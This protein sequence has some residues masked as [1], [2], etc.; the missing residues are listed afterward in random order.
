MAL[1]TLNIDDRTYE[2]LLT[3]LK[4]H[5]PVAE[6][7]D[8][9]PSDPGIMLLELLAW[10]GEMTLYR[11]NRVPEPHKRKFLKLLIDPPEPVMVEVK[12]QLKLA[13]D[14]TDED[15]PIPPGLRFATGFK[16]GKRYT[17]ETFQ[18]T[19]LHSPKAGTHPITVTARTWRAIENE[20]LGVSDG[21]PNQIF[22][23]KHGPVLLDF[24]NKR[25]EYEIVPGSKWEYNPNPEIH[26]NGQPWEL[27]QSLRT[28][29]SKG[30]NKKHVMV[31]DFENVVRFGD[32]EFGAIPTAGTKL[33]CTR[34]QILEGPEALIKA[35]TIQYV[36]NEPEIV[37][38]KSGETLSIDP[39]EGNEDAEGGTNFFGKDNIEELF[40]KGLKNYRKTYRLITSE[41][42][43]NI[44]L[45]DFNELQ[46]DIRENAFNELGGSST[47]S[48]IKLCRAV[49]MMN[50]RPSIASGLEERPGHVTILAIPEFEE[51]PTPPYVTQDKIDLNDPLKG[52][53]LRFLEKRKLITTHLHLIPATLKELTIK[54]AVVIDK[55]RVLSEMEDTIKSRIHVFMSI[56]EGYFN[57]E[58]WPLGKD[59]YKS[60][61]YRL[62]E[63]IEGV[64]HVSYL[65]FLPSTVDGNVKIAEHEL[66]VLRNLDIHITKQ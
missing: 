19:V 34:Y 16:N 22:P 59:L 6:W 47:D 13:S 31:D 17:F 23:L 29:E 32:G 51:N 62:V 49:T 8:H 33:V 60:Q 40:S 20:E 50:R 2:Q 36:L 7:T 55:E 56:L 28:E 14:R 65:E 26:V 43:E 63:D 54:I 30:S 11:M 1:Q 39:V 15:F 12:L 45:Q 18:E 27:K 3:E 66:P 53:I 64:D 61:L 58:G 37:W 10:L 25:E 57:H 41:D 52:K 24:V 46:G 4:Q 35:G 42:F 38:L 21:S 48:T 5:I 44:L 9:N